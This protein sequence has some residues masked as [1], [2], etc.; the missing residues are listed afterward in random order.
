[1]KKESNIGAGPLIVI[2]TDVLTSHKSNPEYN[3]LASSN[4]AILTPEFPTF[5]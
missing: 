3:F 4:E 2:D 1:M 5:P